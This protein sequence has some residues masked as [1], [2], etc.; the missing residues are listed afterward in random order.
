MLTL[1]AASQQASQK[2]KIII[3]FKKK[4]LT[5]G[6]ISLLCYADLSISI[7][8]VIGTNCAQLIK[9]SLNPPPEI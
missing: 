1:T 4:L 6:P 8:P 9:L 3:E 2:N 5:R 7:L